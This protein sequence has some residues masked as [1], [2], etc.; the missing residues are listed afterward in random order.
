MIA[1]TG[2]TGF[3]GSQLVRTLLERGEPVRLLARLRRDR[4][5]TAHVRSPGPQSGDGDIQPRTPEMV[6]GDLRDAASL[7]RLVGGADL[8]FH[9]AACARAWTWDPYEF[10][11][12]NVEGTANL[13]RAARAAGVRRVVHVSTELVDGETTRTSAPSA[14][15]SS[16]CATTWRR[17][18]TR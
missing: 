3:I 1:V 17:A 8:V 9:L 18:E 14:P 2:G 10:E 16:W 5:P 12:V 13:L 15:A 4:H 11:A 7:I 6:P